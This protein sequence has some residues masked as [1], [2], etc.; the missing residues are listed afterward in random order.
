MIEL[1]N[2]QD[3]FYRCTRHLGHSG[4]HE[5][6]DG[7]IIGHRWDNARPKVTVHFIDG[8]WSGQ[9]YEVERVVGP[10]FGAGHE[11]GNHYWLDTKS[12]PPTYF[13]DGSGVSATRGTQEAEDDE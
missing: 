10:V 11:V 5:A 12:D 3:S 1:C 4:D 2:S 7:C 6:R 13:W 8:P 9:S